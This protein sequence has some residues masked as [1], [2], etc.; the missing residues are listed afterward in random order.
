M[1]LRARVEPRSCAS[2]RPGA[3]RSGGQ[4]VLAGQRSVLDIAEAVVV[5]NTA[6]HHLFLG[7]P[8]RQLGLA[9]Y[10]A[11]ESAALDMPAATARLGAGA[12]RKPPPAAQHR[13]VRRRRPRRHA[14]RRRH[15]R[16]RW[17]G[18]RH[19]HRHQH[20]DQPAGHGRHLRLLNRF[21]AGFRR[22]PHPSWHAR[23]A[24]RDRKGAHP[25]RPRIHPNRRGRCPGRVVRLGHP[26]PDGADAR[27]ASRIPAAQCSS[28]I[29]ASDPART[30]W[31][32]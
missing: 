15:R 13:R 11:A 22:R 19:G 21:R 10:V 1:P 28:T 20:R 5:G 30:A 17:G 23:R 25:R 18:A 16:P 24:G 9:P 2:D 4:P 12:R 8:V 3:Q 7:L 29:R 26:G 27:P 6:M 31:N 14:A 32:M